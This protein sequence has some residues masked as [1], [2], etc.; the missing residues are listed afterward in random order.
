MDQ[1]IVD[2]SVSRVHVGCGPH[3]IFS[4]WWNVD[5]RKFKDVDQAMDVTDVWPWENALDYVYAE[6]FLEHL[7]FDQ[8]IKFL[9][10]AGSALRVGGRIRLTTPSLEWVLKS[11]YSFDDHGD[12]KT[13][14]QTWGMNRAFHGWGHQFLYS[15]TMLKSFL[16]AM[17]FDQIEF[18]N[19]GESNDPE[20]ESLEKHGGWR[21]AAGYPTVW[22]LEAE[23][24]QSELIV[25][26]QFLADANDSFIRYVESG[27]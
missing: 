4:G 16:T 9:G 5:I 13:L 20:L 24:T 21:I 17:G 26:K 15:K 11:H 19:Y 25:D 1:N 6:H 8:A 14:Q 12:E 10:N 2:T 3:N 22:I 23:K 18:F 27:H 7:R